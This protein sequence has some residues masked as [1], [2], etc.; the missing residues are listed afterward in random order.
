MNFFEME[1]DKI[2]IHNSVIANSQLNIYVC[3]F[4]L[5]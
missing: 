5:S 1:L 3:L 2:D 4:Y